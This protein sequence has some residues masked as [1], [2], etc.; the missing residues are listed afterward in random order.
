V[1]QG[2]SWHEATDRLRGT[3]V[4]GNPQY[5][6][7]PWSVYWNSDHFNE[8]LFAS[9]DFKNW[10]IIRKSDLVGEDGEKYYSN[11]DIDIQLSS[12]SCQPYKAKMYRRKGNHEDPWV[13]IR[14]HGTAR[15]MVYG[16][17]SA[18]KHIDLLQTT[19]GMNVYIRKNYNQGYDQLN[20]N[21]KRKSNCNPV[22]LLGK[23]S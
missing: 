6:S 18:K 3:D 20:E 10:A 7:E 17:A 5:M 4:Y 2:A 22:K 21:V 11:V 8:F 19:G 1:P 13:S 12:V 15:T 14:D 16:S 9:G 23:F